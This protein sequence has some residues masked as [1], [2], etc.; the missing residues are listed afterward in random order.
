MPVGACDH[1][2]QRDA[3]TVYRD[4]T[5]AAELAPVGRVRPG[6]FA[7]WGLATLAPSTLTRVQSIASYSRNRVGNARCRRAHTPSFCQSRSGASTSCHCQAHFLRQVFPRDAGVQYEENSIQRRPVTYTR[8]PACRRTRPR[9]QQRLKR[10]PQLVIDSLFCHP[11]SNVYPRFRMTR[12][13]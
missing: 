9:G 11:T 4:M 7:P 10:F 13:V 6:L 12:F 1:G 2:C 5:L 8:T 3:L